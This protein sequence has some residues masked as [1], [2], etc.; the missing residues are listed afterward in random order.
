MIPIEW[1]QK[2]PDETDVEAVVR[3]ELPRIGVDASELTLATSPR[4]FTSPPEPWQSFSGAAG[5]ATLRDG[6]ANHVLTRR[7]S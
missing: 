4:L 5:F 6:E 3:R 1:P 2:H 7:R